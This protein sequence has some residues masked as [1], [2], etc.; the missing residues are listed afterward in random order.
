MKIVGENMAV[1]KH[2]LGVRFDDYGLVQFYGLAWLAN[3]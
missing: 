2:G 1:T 3:P